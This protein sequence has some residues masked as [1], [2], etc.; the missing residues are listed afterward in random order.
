MIWAKSWSQ[1]HHIENSQD[2][3]GRGFRNDLK[4]RMKIYKYNELG[5]EYESL[6]LS[7]S[8]CIDN[9]LCCH[10][11]IQF[12]VMLYNQME[13]EVVATKKSILIT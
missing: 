2:D 3:A 4:M 9:T 8:L 6:S 5:F 12:N 1:Q 7:L 13:F 11:K 10:N